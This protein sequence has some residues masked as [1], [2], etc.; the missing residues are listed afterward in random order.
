MST[1]AVTPNP[2]TPGQTI[3]VDGSGFDRK[4]KFAL[5]TVDPNGV[6]VGQSSNTNRP[7]RDGTFHVG[8][9][10][11]PIEGVCKVRA[12][13]GSALVAEALVTTL[14]PP[15]V[16]TPPPTTGVLI[17]IPSWK[18]A[19][20]FDPATQPLDKSKWGGYPSNW[21]DTRYKQGDTKNGG[22][23]TGLDSLSQANGQLVQTLY[24][25]AGGQ[26]RSS[27]IYP[28]LAIGNN[29]AGG[30][31]L[32]E[33]EAD[34]V[35][36]WKTAWLL[37]PASNVWPRDGEIDFPEG[38][39]NGHVSGFVHHQGATSG[40]DQAAASTQATYAT[41]HTAVVEWV[42]GQR[43]EFFLDG[44]SILRETSRVPNTPMHWVIQSETALDGSIPGARAGIRIGKVG[45]WV[46]A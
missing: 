27:A 21:G 22:L 38:N 5:T 46:P 35:V 17:D 32:I 14:V 3:D 45:V 25:D 40:S 15:P 16:V 39:L 33:F 1:I 7:R 28:Q 19:W 20:G 29:L 10:V 37:W 30:R 18:L 44:V 31:F 13:Q 2:A 8:I 4:L 41:R 12:Y 36:G 11:P 9:N 42:P 6:E 23:Y 26:P 43:C 34:Q 24:R